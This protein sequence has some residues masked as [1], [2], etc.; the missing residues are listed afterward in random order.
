MQKEKTEDVEVVQL[1]ILL[2]CIWAATSQKKKNKRK[3]KASAAPVA[4][5]TSMTVDSGFLCCAHH[6]VMVACLAMLGVGM[7]QNKGV[8]M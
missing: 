7:P 1:L 4:S 5:S 3:A 8:C 2:F 6:E